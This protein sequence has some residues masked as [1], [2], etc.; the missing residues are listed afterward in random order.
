MADDDL[1]YLSAGELIDAYEDKRLSPVEATEACLARIDKYN[2]LL[3]AFCLVDG[4]SALTAARESEAR[5]VR[6]EPLGLLDGVP[7]AT[8]FFFP[9]SGLTTPAR[10]SGSPGCSKPAAN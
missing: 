2:D 9:F 4:G 10:P 1:A 3:N 6:G 5:W 7:V 8:R